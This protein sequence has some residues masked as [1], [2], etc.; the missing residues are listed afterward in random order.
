M[1]AGHIADPRAEYDDD[2][3]AAAFAH[4]A[5]R[6]IDQSLAVDNGG[7][8]GPAEAPALARGEHETGRGH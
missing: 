3:I 1:S 2:G 5:H 4:D 7:S 6:A 8:L